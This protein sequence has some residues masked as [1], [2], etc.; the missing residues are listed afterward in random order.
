MIVDDSSQGEVLGVKPVAYGRA[1]L[2]IVVKYIIN[3]SMRVYRSV[4]VVFWVANQ[5][6][7]WLFSVYTMDF[8]QVYLECAVMMKYC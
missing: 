8:M 1:A 7:L 3:G 6:V 5:I 4:F 2:S